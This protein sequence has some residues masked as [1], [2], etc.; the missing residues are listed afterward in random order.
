MNSFL[1]T[2]KFILIFLL[3]ASPFLAFMA[4]GFFVIYQDRKREK[5]EEKKKPE[6][7]KSH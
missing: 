3:L 1:D 7:A 4:F 5:L 6:E 2:I